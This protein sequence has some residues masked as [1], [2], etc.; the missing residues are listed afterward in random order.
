[1]TLSGGVAQQVNKFSTGK[2]AY[3]ITFSVVDVSVTLTLTGLISNS[4]VR[5]YTYGTTTELAGIENSSTTFSYEYVYVAS[6]YVDIIIV[7][8]SYQ[9]YKIENLLLTNSSSSIPVQQILDR[10]YS[11]L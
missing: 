10:V 6:T 5:I 1:M 8:D 7:N 11:N 2:Y 9:Y 4:E 3:G